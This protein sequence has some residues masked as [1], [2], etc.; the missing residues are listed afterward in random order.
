MAAKAANRP[1]LDG[2]QRLMLARQPQDQIAVQRL[3]ETRIGHRGRNATGRQRFCRDQ[4]FGKTC[5]KAQDRNAR[6][7]ADHPA[8]SDL[9]R[10]APCRQVHAN[11]VPARK[12][13]GNRTAVMRRRRGHHVHKLGLIRRRHDDKAGQVGQKGHI[14]GPGMGRP[15]GPDQ[16]GPVDGKAHRQALDRHVMHHLIIAALQ[17]GRI[18][19]AERLQPPG[20]HA[21]AEG[22]G[23]LLGDA[24][25]EAA[26]GKAFREQ[27]KPGSV[28]HGRRHGH[29]PLIR[30][31]L[32]DQR[33]RKDLG[34]GGRVRDGLCLHARQD[35]ELRRRMAPV[36]RRLGGGIALA[37][38]GDHMNQHRPRGPRLDRAQHRQ[39]LVKIMSVDRTHIG[40]AQLL[41]QCPAHGHAFQHF[42]GAPRPH[43][44]RLGQQADRP[45]CRRL[46]F[47]KRLARIKP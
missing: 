26:P 14:K 44:E 39:Q 32:P 45:L 35:I 4:H 5:P 20:C 37:L 33:L 36:P 27:V 40:K 13:E 47:L 29:N 17:E 30:F 34:I 42:L 21:R 9:Q 38:P 24:N 25:I 6:T 43:L 12:A 23:M 28:R 1:F 10:H 2:D 15:I 7:L 8:P 31:G 19:R 22:D 16:T 3:G 11:S 18:D 46:Q 41:E